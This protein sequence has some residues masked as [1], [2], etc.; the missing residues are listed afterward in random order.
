MVA[1]SVIVKALKG[2]CFRN[3]SI[4]LLYQYMGDY[5]RTTINAYVVSEEDVKKFETLLEGKSKK[6]IRLRCL[7]K[8][9]S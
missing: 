6:D 9:V 8:G 2:E 1:L 7:K 4:T 3:F 5:L